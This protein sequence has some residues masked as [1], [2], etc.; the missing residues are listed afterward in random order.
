MLKEKMYKGGGNQ[1][2]EKRNCRRTVECGPQVLI[3]FVSL[4][5]KLMKSPLGTSIQ[6]KLLLSRFVT[7]RID[8]LI[9]GIVNFFIP[10]RMR[11]RFPVRP[12]G[13]T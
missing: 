9:N 7:K 3:R 11:I 13:L 5:L 10:G 2:D 12:H 4:K 1:Q 6:I 8:P